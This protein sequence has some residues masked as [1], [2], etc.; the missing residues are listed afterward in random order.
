MTLALP[1]KIPISLLPQIDT[2]RRHPIFPCLLNMV[3]NINGLLNA[4]SGFYKTSL[5]PT[6]LSVSLSFQ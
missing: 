4:Q 6:C 5:L 2:G 1:V 3:N